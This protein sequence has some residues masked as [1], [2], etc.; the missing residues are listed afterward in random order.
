MLVLSK[1]RYSDFT[2]AVI[3]SLSF[4]CQ[5]QVASTCQQLPS[6]QAMPEMM[7]AVVE[8]WWKSAIARITV[9]RP[10]QMGRIEKLAKLTS[11][12]TRHSLAAAHRR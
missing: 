10:R 9:A 3:L 5:C 4:S 8:L 12:Q 6:R 11:I 1:S 2:A 7:G